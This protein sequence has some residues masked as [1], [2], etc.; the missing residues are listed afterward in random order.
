[1]TNH[2]LKVYVTEIFMGQM[3]RCLGLN[4]NP[5]REREEKTL[6]DG[7]RNTRLSVS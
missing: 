3:M 2:I 1:M 6:G 4:S 5:F 7:T